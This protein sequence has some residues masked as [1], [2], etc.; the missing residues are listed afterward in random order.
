MKEINDE[1]LKELK[2][3]YGI[4]L[5]RT[6]KSIL[7]ATIAIK[8]ANDHIRKLKIWCNVFGIA[9]IALAVLHIIR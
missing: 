6:V 2:S 3:D 7:S 1:T 8:L 9:T 4:D 5:A